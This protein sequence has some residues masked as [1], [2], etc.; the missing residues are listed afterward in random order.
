MSTPLRVLFVEDS[1]EDVRFLVGELR[2]GGYNLTFDQVDTADAM[3]AALDKKEWDVI[4]DNYAMPKFNGRVALNLL[5]EKGLDLPFII[6]SGGNG[7]ERV[8]EAMKA[9]AHDYI[10]KKNITRLIPTIERELK[11][12]ETRRG[13]KREEI[14]IESDTQ[15]IKKTTDHLS[16]D[17]RTVIEQKESIAKEEKFEVLLQFAGTAAHKL[18]QPLTA[19][20][21]NIELMRLD[22]DNPEQMFRYMD[23]VEEAGRQV[24]NIVNNIRNIR[25]EIV[26][27]YFDGT[28]IINLDRKLHFLSV[29][30]SDEDFETINTILKDNSQVNISRA[31]N[32]K[33]AIR[34]LEN[35]N[36]DFVLLD[37][38][39]PDGNSIDFLRSIHEKGME[40]PVMVI[41]GQGDEMTASEAIQSGA[42]DYLPKDKL[43]K[44]SLSRSINNSLEK[45]RLAKEMKLAMKKMAEMSSKDELTGLYNRRCFMETLEREMARA[46]R[47][48]GYLVL[49][50]ID[51]DHFKHV[52]DTYGHPAGD[53]VLSEIGEMLIKSFRLSVMIC[54][55]GGEEFSIIMPNTK[56]PEAR[57]A[58]ERFRKMVAG[59]TFNHD[60]AHLNITVSIGVAVLDCASSKLPLD[61]IT[62]AD[63]AL[64]QAKKAGRNKVIERFQSV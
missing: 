62:D 41:T 12:A 28:C 56:G 46:K 1:E 29:E 64:Y 45:F 49:C 10:M 23:N 9:G 43:S 30:D 6:V 52:N 33:E 21:G 22:K 8:V 53:A 16:K 47:Y 60:G 55:Y 18:N 50:M 61:L 51:L 2:K 11:E 24:A 17:N 31:R 25:H 39:L 20:L 42:Y 7:E 19:L 37:H 5:K 27:P 44:K 3:R 4:I 13:Q 14:L 34:A 36:F 32:L 26:K 58:C 35:N 63:Q 38:V 48:K 15:D 59:H 40:L 54:R 57:I